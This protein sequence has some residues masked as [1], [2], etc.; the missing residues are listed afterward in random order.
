MASAEGGVW[1]GCPFPS[2]LEG[3]GSI[4]STPSGVRGRA[5]AGTA[6]W[7]ILKATERSCLYLY[8]DALSNLV[9]EILQHEKI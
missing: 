7:R 9:L 1:K 8:A 6:F 2:R 4:V 3:L 5:L